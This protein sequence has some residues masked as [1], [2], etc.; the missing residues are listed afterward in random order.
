MSFKRC[1]Q[2]KVGQPYWKPV[3]GFP[4]KF[5][6]QQGVWED[7]FDKHI[8]Y[9]QDELRRA[10]AEDRVIVYLS[11]PISSCGGG[12]H[13]TNVDIAAHTA[14][15][16][17][18]QWGPR[19]FILNPTQYQLESKE[20]TGLIRRHVERIALETGQ[21]INIDQLIEESPP[22]GGDYMRMWTKVL[23]EDFYLNDEKRRNKNRGGLFDTYYFLAFSDM[24]DFFTK[25]GATT[26][27][28]GVEE[29]FSRKFSMDPEFRSF[30]SSST[31]WE[32]LRKE[33]FRFYA[34]RG[35][36][37]FSKGCHDEWNIWFELNKMR[38]SDPD[39][40]LG[41]QIAGYFDGK[42]IDPGS[43]ENRITQGY[44]H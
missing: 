2:Q 35:S 9:I 19:F 1:P 26:V 3:Q 8:D 4:I 10:Q 14:C 39:Y 17:M 7:I 20:G 28:V 34:V 31:N 18:M 27:T 38:M 44:S 11:C 37:D 21:T 43:S 41:E 30:F 33:F 6:W 22:T 42:Q 40:G 25:G 29:Y 23:V 12:H 16:L 13:R 32:K 24:W 36:A 15:R 5:E